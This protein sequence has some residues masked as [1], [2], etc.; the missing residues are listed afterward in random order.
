MAILTL[1]ANANHTDNENRTPLHIAAA[2]DN[3]AAVSALLET[4]TVDINARDIAGWTPLHF[5]AGTGT[6]AAGVLLTTEGISLNALTD[7]ELTPLDFA[8]L[9]GDTNRRTLFQ[10]MDATLC[11]R[12]CDLVAAQPIIP[13]LSI[14]VDVFTP[15]VPTPAGIVALTGGYFH[16]ALS[17]RYHYRPLPN[18][19]AVSVITPPLTVTTRNLNANLAIITNDIIP[20]S[21][22]TIIINMP[23]G[24]NHLTVSIGFTDFCPGF[25]MRELIQGTPSRSS[26]GAIGQGIPFTSGCANPVTIS[27]TVTAAG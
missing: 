21:H 1:S 20:D 9:R 13:S 12:Y 22:A 25:D 18:M 14:T 2:A 7:N 19:T 5:A 4:G 26:G 15:G 3:A 23:V 24:A 10:G 6:M 27:F 16:W 8:I 17:Y 11:I